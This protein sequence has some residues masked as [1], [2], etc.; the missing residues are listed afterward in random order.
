MND[1]LITCAWGFHPKLLGG[2]PEILGKPVMWVDVV[3]GIP[4]TLRVNL[5]VQMATIRI[6][7]LTDC[8]DLLTS[9]HPV[10]ITHE[11]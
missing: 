7:H 11:D 5:K 3:I 1:L 4:A 10:T 2:L 6:T 8:A 9:V